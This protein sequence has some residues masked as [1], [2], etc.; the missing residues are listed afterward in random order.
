MNIKSIHIKNVRGLGD[1]KIELNMIPNK[2][3]LLV[4]PNGSGKSSFAFA[5]QWLNRIRMKLN[6]DDAYLG[7][8]GN[9]PSMVIETVNPNEVLTADETKNDIIKK[10]GVYVIN[11]SLK[12]VSPSLHGGIPTG[13]ARI[14]VPEIVLIDHIPQNKQLID[15]FEEIYELMGM[16]KGYSIRL[17]KS[18]W[19]IILLWLI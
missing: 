9:K 4:A 3:S 14:T 6:E 12:A 8:V 2:P 15:D 5:F 11:N 13:K 1:R 19:M 16:P 17:F 7:N 18:Y 10:F